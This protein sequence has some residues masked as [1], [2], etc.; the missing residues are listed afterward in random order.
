[1]NNKV[2]AQ[3]GQKWQRYTVREKAFII[4]LLALLILLMILPVI[5][6]KQLNTTSPD[7]YTVFNSN[8]TKTRILLLLTIGAMIARNMSFKFKKMIHRLFGFTANDMLVNTFLLFVVLISIFSIGDTAALIRQNFSVSISTTSGFLIIGVFI[9]LG[10]A[11]TIIS[12]RVQRKKESK[13]QSVTVKQESDH[14]HH[15]RGFDQAKK[16]FEGLFGGDTTQQ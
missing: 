6:I 11:W 10:I 8:M 4:Y 15:E 5:S 1:M 2:T 16:E 12:A 3:V 13:S 7:T 14:T 9:V